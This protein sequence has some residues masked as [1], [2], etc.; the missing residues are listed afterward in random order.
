[1]MQRIAGLPIGQELTV[2]FDQRRVMDQRHIVVISEAGRA[3][4]DV[5]AEPG[6]MTLYPRMG[7]PVFIEPGGVFEIQVIRAAKQHGWPPWLFNEHKWIDLEILHAAALQ[8]RLKYAS[9][10]TSSATTCMTRRWSSSPA[11]TT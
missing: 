1:M 5:Q 8:N 2:H 11:T 6:I 9:R 7:M 4:H 3:I 10:P